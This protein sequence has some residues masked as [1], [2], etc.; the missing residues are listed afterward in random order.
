MLLQSTVSVTRWWVGRDD[1]TL[2]EPTS[3]HEKRL[4]TRTQRSCSPTTM[5]P[6]LFRRS[7]APPHGEVVMFHGGTAASSE[8]AV[9]G[10]FFVSYHSFI[11]FFNDLNEIVGKI[12]YIIGIAAKQIF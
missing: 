12:N 2:P 10:S 9:L 6:A 1:T 4:K 11:L 7:G 8:N 3:S 5:A